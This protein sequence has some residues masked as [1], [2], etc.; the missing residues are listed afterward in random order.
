MSVANGPRGFA[1]IVLALIVS[2]SLPLTALQAQDANAGK[3]VFAQ[4][5]SC[6]STDGTN[7]MGPSLEGVVGRKAGTLAGFR[8]SRAMKNAGFAW[9][10][11]LLDDYIADPQKV[12][13]GN[14]MPF[15][16]VADARQRADLIAYLITLR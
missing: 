10:T 12:L 2:M 7:G 13:P 5:S 11:R 6:H 14:L 4:C 3:R 8:Y 9:T 16:G 15:S 1:L